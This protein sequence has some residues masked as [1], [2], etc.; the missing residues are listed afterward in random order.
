MEH[1]GAVRQLG[2]VVAAFTAKPPLICEF[3]TGAG[4]L[5]RGSGAHGNTAAAPMNRFTNGIRPTVRL[6]EV[7]R[8]NS[9]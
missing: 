5:E 2:A 3:V 6:S 1:E 8:A 7:I 4:E 9:A